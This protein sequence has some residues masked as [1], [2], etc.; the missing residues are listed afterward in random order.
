M[1]SKEIVIR[2]ITFSSPER[3][4]FGFHNGRF[5]DITWGGA[6]PTTM[7]R[8][9]RDLQAEFPAFAGELWEDE[10]GNVWGRLEELTKGESLAGAIREW[11]DVDSYQWPDLDN[12]QRYLACAENWRQQPDKYHLGGIAGWGFNICR[13]LRKFET[14]LMDVAAEPEEVEKL[15]AKTTELICR[16]IAC[17]AEAGADGI[18]VGED[19]GTQDRLL[20]SPKSWRELFQPGITKCCEYAHSLGLQVWMHSCG[21]VID[22]IPELIK[23]GVDVFQFDQPG[24]HG[25]ERLGREFGGQV[26]FW[27]PVDIQTTMQSGDRTEIERVANLLVDEL[28]KFNG[29]FIAGEYPSW[30]AINVPAESAD[31]ACNAFLARGGNPQLAKE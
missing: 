3:L 6:S 19:W 28:G 30:E 26:T 5:T 10:W 27:C 20:I 15:L 22:I 31:W 29:G 8:P 1:T 18:M 13:Y 23:S 14:Y 11:E 16:E 21:Y 4:A 25:A 24:L 17:M 9:P 12:P 7:K 2:T